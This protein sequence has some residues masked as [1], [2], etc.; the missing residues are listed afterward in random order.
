MKVAG[1]PM[2][3]QMLEGLRL[4]I[5]QFKDGENFVV[6]DDWKNSSDPHRRLKQPWTGCTVFVAKQ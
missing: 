2:Q 4:T 6:D 1:G 3:S 5:G